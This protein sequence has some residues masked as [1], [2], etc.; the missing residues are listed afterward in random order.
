MG[1]ECHEDFWDE[2]WHIV[3]EGCDTGTEAQ[4][5]CVSFDEILGLDAIRLS[6]PLTL[7]LCAAQTLKVSLKNGFENMFRLKHILY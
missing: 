2:F 6:G 1:T 3:G 4:D 7:H 5:A